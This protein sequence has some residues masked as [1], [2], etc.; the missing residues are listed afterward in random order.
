[1]QIVMSSPSSFSNEDHVSTRCPVSLRVGKLIYYQGLCFEEESPS[2]WFPA[3]N[4]FWTLAANCPSQPTIYLRRKAAS[5]ALAQIQ[6]WSKITKALN[7]IFARRVL[8]TVIKALGALCR[9]PR[10]ISHLFTEPRCLRAMYPS[11]RQQRLAIWNT[12]SP[13]LGNISDVMAYPRASCGTGCIEF[14]HHLRIHTLSEGGSCLNLDSMIL[15]QDIREYKLPCCL[16]L[17]PAWMAL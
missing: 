5:Y 3:A 1:M 16:V 12:G 13:S 11:W 10:L 14:V 7:G 15:S 2:P 6:F 17:V 8:D 4:S 9:R